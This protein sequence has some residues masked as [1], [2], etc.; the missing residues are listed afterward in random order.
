M[1]AAVAAGD[2]RIAGAGEAM[3]SVGRGG[4]ANGARQRASSV[5]RYET[6]LTVKP[7]CGALVPD[8]AEHRSGLTVGRCQSIPNDAVSD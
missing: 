3:A 8:T 2:S 1:N 4:R 5:L 6:M 7:P